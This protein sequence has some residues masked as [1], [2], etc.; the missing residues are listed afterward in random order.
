ME[1]GT[2]CLK[3]TKKVIFSTKAQSILFLAG[4]GRPVP[5]L[6]SLADARVKGQ[7]FSIFYE[8]KKLVMKK[9][10]VPYYLLK[11]CRFYDVKNFLQFVEEH[12]FLGRVDL[13]PEPQKCHNDL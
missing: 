12:D 1:N 6:P 13:R 2:I 5:L 10:K 8:G 11:L 3:N 7:Q 4:R 9:Y